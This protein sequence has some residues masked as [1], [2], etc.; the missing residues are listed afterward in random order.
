MLFSFFWAGMG[1]TEH[2]VPGDEGRGQGGGVYSPQVDGTVHLLPGT[3]DAGDGS[4]QHL[5][6]HQVL[7]RVPITGC[8]TLEWNGAMVH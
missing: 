6:L 5:P 1:G 2:D 8:G 7:V 3:A 4:P